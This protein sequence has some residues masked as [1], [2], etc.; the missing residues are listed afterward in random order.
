MPTDDSK[1]SSIHSSFRQMSDLPEI[2]KL[3]ARADVAESLRRIREFSEENR[4]SVH[5]SSL[6]YHASLQAGLTTLDP[7][8]GQ[9][10]GIW[11]Q[12]KLKEAAHFALSRSTN[13]N[14]GQRYDG[15]TPT[16]YEIEPNF[17]NLA[18]FPDESSLYAFSVGEEG[19]YL[20]INYHQMRKLLQSEGYDGIFLLKEKTVSAIV[21]S[22][23]AVKEEHDAVPLYMDLVKPSLVARFGRDPFLAP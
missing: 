12:P 5:I 23:I 22:S 4:A 8:K 20:G 21:S 2:Q 11:M 15:V 6:L 18:I 7:Q 14:S 10:F 13:P 9:G 3:K 19:P 17:K 16:I 1:P